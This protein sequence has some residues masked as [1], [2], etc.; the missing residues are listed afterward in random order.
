[1]PGLHRKRKRATTDDQYAKML[2]RMLSAWKPR[3]TNDPMTGLAHVR[4]FQQKLDDAANIAI[5]HA[6]AGDECQPRL[7]PTAVAEVFGVSRQAIYKR[8]EAGAALTQHGPAARET[9]T[10]RIAQP[11][12]L[13]PGGP[14]ASAKPAS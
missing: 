8:A 7:S 1:M 3:L 11:R 2:A 6:L 4:D 10:A 12:E 14:P 13:P 9:T 5:Y